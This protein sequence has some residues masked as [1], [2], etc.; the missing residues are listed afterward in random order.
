MDERLQAGITLFNHEEFF[1]CH[2]VLEEV[3]TP[4][5]G[6]RRMFLQALIHVAVA[7][8]HCQRGNS[9]G[10]RG[11]LRKALRKLV[12]Y[13]PAFEDIDTRMLYSD[14]T[15]ALEQIE[16]DQRLAG[17]PRIHTLNTCPVCS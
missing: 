12:P 9:A 13:L 7:F 11:Q 15:T 16:R 10:A 14:A 17:F 4:Q 1:E 6:P 3:W 5:Q 8:Y 2:E